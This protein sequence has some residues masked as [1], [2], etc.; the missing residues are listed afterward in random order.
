MELTCCICG[1]TF[2]VTEDDENYELVLLGELMDLDFVCAFCEYDE[3]S[4]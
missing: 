3:A 1:K 2:E 4:A